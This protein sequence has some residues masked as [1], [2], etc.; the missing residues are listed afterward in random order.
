MK[1]LLPLLLWIIASITAIAGFPT[2]APS[3]GYAFEEV[4]PA[5][6]TQDPYS[7]Q[8]IGFRS[9]GQLYF[10]S[11][12]QKG[13]IQYGTNWFT[14]IDNQSIAF[15]GVDT[16]MPS[17]LEHPTDPTRWFSFGGEKEI[18]NGVTNIYDVIREWRL[19]PGTQ[20]LTM[21]RIILRQF[22]RS[23]EHLGFAARFGLDRYLYVCLSDEGGQGD[24]YQNSQRIDGNFFSAVMRIDVDGRPGNLPPN[25][26]PAILGQ[27][28]VPADNPYVGATSFNGSPVDPAKVRTEF[29][30]V[31]L[32]NPNTMTMDTDGSLYIGDVGGSL[33][34][35][36]RKV[37]RGGNA[38]W[39]AVEG[40]TPTRFPT[41]S[42]T[43]SRPPVD[44]VPPILT[45]PHPDV[46]PGW[47]K[48]YEGYCVF[49]GPV[50]HGSRYPELEGSLIVSDMSGAVWALNLSSNIITRIATHPTYAT[51]WA[52]DPATGDLLAGSLKGHSVTRMVRAV[53]AS[54]PQTLS[55]TGLFSDVETLTPNGGKPY[56]VAAPFFSDYAEKTRWAFKAPSGKIS[57]DPNDRWK[58][59]AGTRLVK[60]FNVGGR[61]AE[62]RI[63]VFTTNA[64]YGLSYKWR[65]DGSDA[66]LASPYGETIDTPA[67][68]W[69]IP[70]WADCAR[71]HT[72]G[73]GFAPG[74]RTAQLNVDGQLEAFSADGWFEEPITNAASLPRLWPYD[75]QV[76]LV[77]RVKSYLDS[78][79]SHCHQP[80][81]EGRGEWDPRITTPME[82]S[83]IINGPVSDTLGLPNARVIAPGS[84]TNSVLWQRVAYHE[85]GVLPPFHM[86]PLATAR[87][88]VE[89]ANLL[90]EYIGS[91]AA[92]TI[93]EIGT[94]GPS[95]TPY[96]EFSQ[97][98]GRND[99][100]PGSP[101]AM[102]DDYYTA[103]TYPSG[104]NWLSSPLVVES[105][106]PWINWERALTM[107]DVENRI[108]L[109]TSAGPATLTMGLNLG[110]TIGTNGLKVLPV[111]H[112][113]M[114]VHRAADGTELV[115]ANFQ[116]SASTVITIPFDATDGPQSIRIVRL[117]PTSSAGGR[118]VSAWM[119]FDYVRVSR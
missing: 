20:R 96:G 32:R 54:I 31:G 83:G 81:G 61:R 47:S 112:Q 119:N 16:G 10:S 43:V 69:R 94:N 49:V 82:L 74:F 40:I 62:T 65:A 92:R 98:N 108:H 60:H 113:I 115:L 59:P 12:D 2:V 5:S 93:W 21:V 91:L 3:I 73:Y 103:G 33:F 23:P 67:G 55:A 45:Y 25:P 111:L 100:A 72:E 117:G 8:F 86:P 1:Y 66:D 109:V 99:P 107:T 77:T 50:M 14:L 42:A 58:L 34:E 22:D 57:R 106:E 63:T 6:L 52:V 64:A 79:C 51:C 29:Y 76:P 39:A 97:E 118:Y 110:S 28:W 53:P 17:L 7:P 36:V 44:F 116:I 41:G 75:A 85:G 11:R 68:P 4:V 35:S 26:H 48:Q 27:Y 95:G 114:V 78:N 84:L 18:V 56:K 89:G 19:A 70:G 30:M 80:G 71:C 13:R 90:A 9:N 101:S 38:G 102:D 105:D 88:N 24:P 15:A 104:F 87:V 46:V 37:V